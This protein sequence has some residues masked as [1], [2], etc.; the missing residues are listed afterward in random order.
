M[1]AMPPMPGAVL[2]VWRPAAER[3]G[4]SHQKEFRWGP[5]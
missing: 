3:P 5:P 4:R 1:G 2:N